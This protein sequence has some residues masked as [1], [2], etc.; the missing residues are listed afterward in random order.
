MVQVIRGKWFF[1]VLLYVL[2]CYYLSL[3]TWCRP[4]IW[5]NFPDSKQ[6]IGQ[7]WV[8]VGVVGNTSLLAC[9]HWLNIV[10]TLKFQQLK[11]CCW[12]N[13]RTSNTHQ[14]WIL[15]WPKNVLAD[16][17]RVIFLNIKFILIMQ[18]LYNLLSDFVL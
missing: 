16:N 2:L 5:T 13:V 1:K 11:Y 3:E 12:P 17:S 8:M 9:W 14:R 18:K 6:S 10:P 7:R 4:L 15:S